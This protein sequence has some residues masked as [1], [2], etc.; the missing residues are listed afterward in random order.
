[1]ATRYEKPFA[2][3]PL[4]Q[5][6]LGKKFEAI[7]DASDTSFLGL[8]KAMIPSFLTSYL[9]NYNSEIAR[10]KDAAIQE[11]R[12]NFLDAQDAVQEQLTNN[13]PFRKGS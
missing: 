9:G 8:I 10:R 5:N 12:D 2:Q 1:M 4:V 13:E 3:K 6:L 7:S 11:V